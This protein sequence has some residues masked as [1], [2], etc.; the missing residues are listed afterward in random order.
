MGVTSLQILQ[1]YLRPLAA[2]IDLS[3]IPYIPVAATRQ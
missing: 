2:S 1:E 3:R